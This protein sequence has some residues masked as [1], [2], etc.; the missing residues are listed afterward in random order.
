MYA[1]SLYLK[2]QG[3]KYGEVQDEINE[4]ISA[5]KSI[6]VHTRSRNKEDC[7]SGENFNIYLSLWQGAKSEFVFIPAA[8][9]KKEGDNFIHFNFKIKG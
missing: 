7:Y 9:T 6:F 4:E 1:C 3:C 8:V 2:A 5:R